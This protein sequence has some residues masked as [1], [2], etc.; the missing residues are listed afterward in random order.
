MFTLRASTP[1]GFRSL[2]NQTFR[3]ITEG[4]ESVRLADDVDKTAAEE[5]SRECP[6]A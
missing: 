5:I 3:S 2:S 6:S 4:A 1:C